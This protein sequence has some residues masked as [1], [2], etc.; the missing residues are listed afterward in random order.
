[1][2]YLIAFNAYS[3][4]AAQAASLALGA[5]TTLSI[6]LLAA[7]ALI[8]YFAPHIVSLQISDRLLHL[9]RM[10]LRYFATFFLLAPAIVSFAFVF[11]WAN[12][13]NSELRFRERCHW[14]IDVVWSGPGSH[15]ESYAPSL[16]AW[17]AG[18]I[19]RLIATLIIVVSILLSIACVTSHFPSHRS[20]II[21]HRMLMRIPVDHHKLAMRDLDAATRTCLPTPLPTNHHRQP[22]QSAQ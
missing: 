17:L 5:S 6:T 20:F 21:S 9:T 19:I 8:S 15:C 11:A 18:S 22:P 13:S 1:M 7:S 10:T 12:S 2:R 16:G 14:D 4:S 3:S